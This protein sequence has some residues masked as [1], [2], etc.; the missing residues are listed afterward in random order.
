MFECTLSNGQ[1]FGKI[2]SALSEMTETGNF[3]VDQNMI[4]FQGMDATNVSL[5]SLQLFESGFVHYRCD[6]DECIGIQL[7]S[8]NKIMKYMTS[9]DSLSIECHHDAKSIGF[10]FESKDQQRRTNFELKLEDIDCEQLGIPDIGYAVTVRMPSAEF[11]KICRDLA[12][13]GDAVTISV[14][15]EGITFAVDGYI[16]SGRIT[17]KQKEAESG[18]CNQT[19]IEMFIFMMKML[20]KSRFYEVGMFLI[21]ATWAGSREFLSF[22]DISYIVIGHNK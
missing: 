21:L 9:S 5:V 1:I 18:I 3:M 10:V 19:G 16:G 17:I 12:A 15:K 6:N 14:N 22:S 2:V 4:S 8:L 13:I 11:Q 20:S 7:L